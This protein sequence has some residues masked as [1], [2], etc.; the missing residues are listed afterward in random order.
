M[1]MAAASRVNREQMM[2]REDRG[3]KMGEGQGRSPREGRDR[4]VQGQ[5][6]F[7]IPESLDVGLNMRN[8][9]TKY[10]KPNV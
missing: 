9:Q 4:R 7:G 8:D 5:A 3:C 1:D 6:V 10:D 2:G